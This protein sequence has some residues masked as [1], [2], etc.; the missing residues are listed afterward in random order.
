MA[1]RS[2]DRSAV[3]G[4][5]TAAL[6]F[7]LLLS[8]GVWQLQRLEW[9]EALIDRMTARLATRPVMLPPN[10][11]RV[12]DWD[13]R[14]VTVRGRYAY[15]A[16]LFLAGKARDNRLGYELVTPLRRDGGAPVLVNRGW[17]PVSWREAPQGHQAGEVE[18]NGVARV[19]TEPG[20]FVPDNEPAAN[21]WFSMDLP[22]MASAAGLGAVAPVYVLATAQ[23]P[24]M[25]A[26]LR[27]HRV[28]PDLPN[29]HLGYALTWF[30]LAAV[31]GVIFVL[32]M[33]GRRAGP[34]G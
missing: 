21:N 3:V 33:R 6:A 13:F 11:E 26:D 19:P 16:T 22:R 10:L 34:A 32:Y 12:D 27:P 15:Q 23:E 30:A 4:T 17:V 8:L 7:V 29:R 28:T 25:A 2:A 24:A 18:V 1:R 14:P 31:L 5:V 20:A 9:K